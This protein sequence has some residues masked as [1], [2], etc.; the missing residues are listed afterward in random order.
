[1]T[2]SCYGQLAV[3]YQAGLRRH[4]GAHCVLVSPTSAT[5]LF[6]NLGAS[7]LCSLQKISCNSSSDLSWAVWTFFSVG[8]FPVTSISAVSLQTAFSH[9]KVILGPLEN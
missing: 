3:E 7:L 8:S 9:H 6:P 4:H 1:M 5:L 2:F